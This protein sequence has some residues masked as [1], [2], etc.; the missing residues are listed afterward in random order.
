MTEV[1]F[2]DLATKTGFASRGESGVVV[3]GVQVMPETGNDWGWFLSVYHDWL[4]EYINCFDRDKLV[5]VY[6][7]P[8][9]GNVTAIPK[10]YG[11][12]THTEFVCHRLGVWKCMSVTVNA[13]RSHFIGRTR[14]GRDF[15]KNCAV[16]ECRKRG[17]EPATDDEAEAI[18]GLDYA[19]HLLKLPN[20]DPGG[21]FRAKQAAG[22]VS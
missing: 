17:F 15:L 6:E 7:A 1:I 16:E 19:C 4:V 12:A 21:L 22:K 9:S 20:L 13:W 10:L 2:L 11:L 18:G 5:V 14:G 8:F 3:S